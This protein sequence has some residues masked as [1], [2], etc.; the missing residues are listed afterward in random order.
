MTI[1]KPYFMSNEAWYRFDEENYRIV[2]EHSGKVYGLGDSV[3]V[4]V[5]DADVTSGTIDFSFTEKEPRKRRGYRGE[6]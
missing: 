4:M 2:G 1:E 6:K 3:R 5:E